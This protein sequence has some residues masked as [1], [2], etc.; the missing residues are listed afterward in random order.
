MADSPQE[1]HTRAVLA[2]AFERVRKAVHQSAE[3]LDGEAL[4][5]RPEAAANSIAWLVW[6]LT[7]VQ[8]DHVSEI[9]GREQAW[10]S[11]GWAAEFGM[12]SDPS[13]TGY[14]H[15]SEEVAGVRP[16]G[17]QVLV[18]YHDAVSDRT[19][20][21]LGII[22]A[23]E[24]GRIIDRSYDPPVSV[25]VRLVSVISDNLQHVGQARY[26]RGILERRA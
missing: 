17:P 23:G 13:N 10:T 22:D 21:Y 15:S 26:V 6:H 20:E 11:D 12:P 8:D 9:A 1:L 3:G 5:F 7:R 25:R 16:K 14:G 4:A 2:D 24:L 18:G 19:L